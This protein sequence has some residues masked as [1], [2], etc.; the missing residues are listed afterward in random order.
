MK[1][2]ALR[3]EINGKQIAVAGAE[4]LSLLSGQVALGAGSSGSID[5][6]KIVFNVIGLGVAG[7]RPRQL[8]WGDGVQLKPGD[9]VTFEVVETEAPTLPSGAR[10][11]PNAEELP[12]AAL[13]EK[14]AVKRSD[15]DT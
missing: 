14:R 11:T 15:D 13:A 6:G 2:P 12:S 1:I 9:K 7:T 5:L 10:R 3:I 4:N 8:T